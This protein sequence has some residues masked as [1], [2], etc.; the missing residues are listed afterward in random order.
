MAIFY[1][2]FIEFFQKNLIEIKKQSRM[3]HNVSQQKLFI[4]SIL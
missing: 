3:K 1:L 4:K 2:K